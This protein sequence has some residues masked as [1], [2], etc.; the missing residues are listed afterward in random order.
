MKK[1]SGG[2]R[3]T[4]GIDLLEFMDDWWKQNWKDAVSATEDM[5]RMGLKV[6]AEL[7][8]GDIKTRTL[9]RMGHPLARRGNVAASVSTKSGVIQG[10]KGVGRMRSATRSV[11]ER[12]GIR[13]KGVPLL[14]INIQSGR[15]H[16]SFRIKKGPP[17]GVRIYFDLVSVGVRYAKW[18][19][20]PSGTRKMIGRGI[21]TELVRRWKV[22]AKS[23]ADYLDRNE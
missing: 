22:R 9:R 10:G 14:P 2:R 17:R 21:I 12:N 7:T 4:K 23:L 8:S 20:S 11:R 3:F 13:G 16:A 6:A 18:I 1:T 19:L 15:L 5:A